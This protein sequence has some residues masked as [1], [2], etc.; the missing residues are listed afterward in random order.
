MP[1]KRQAEEVG[2]DAYAPLQPEE[3]PGGGLFTQAVQMAND[4]IKKIEE[5][6]GNELQK[7]SPAEEDSTDSN[8]TASQAGGGGLGTQEMLMANDA[9]KKV[10]AGGEPQK[11]S[12]AEDEPND[13]SGGI[14]GMFSAPTK[15]PPDFDTSISTVGDVVDGNHPHRAQKSLSE[16]YH[17]DH[18]QALL[19]AA[20]DSTPPRLAKVIKLLNPAFA[21]LFALI[22]T[23]GPPALEVWR[24]LMF[25]SGKL[26][27][28]VST[29]FARRSLNRSLS[30][31]PACG[32]R[33]VAR[34]VCWLACEQALRALY[35]LA[36]CFFGGI[37][38]NTIAAVEAFKQSGYERAR[39]CFHDLRK[40]AAELY[41]A[42]EKDNL[43][44]DNH[45]GVADVDQINKQQL[46]SRKMVLIIRTVD[47]T[48]LQQAFIGLYQGF[49]GVLASLRFKFAKSIALGLS[50]GNMA[51][52]PLAV[53][54]APTL[55]HIM[56]P[57]KALPAIRAGRIRCV[58]CLVASIGPGC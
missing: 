15:L 51:R 41:E 53:V 35:G 9:I 23:V 27:H 31:S 52:R 36:L 5:S 46:L 11:E 49:I 55:K 44:D 38:A 47:P 34:G 48:V 28:S 40:A 20:V 4:A 22:D 50:I 42:N 16:R 12:P 7:E 2:G 17:S 25:V 56:K 6:A 57:G 54:L 32:V 10:D 45:D 19:A 18:V 21:K 1:P 14:M 29:H 43:R 8:R 30:K 33:C 26:P 13:S 58:Q 24:K 37:F 39:T 3:Q